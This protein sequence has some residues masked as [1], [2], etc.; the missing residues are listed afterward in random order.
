[1]LLAGGEGP[2]EASGTGPVTAIKPFELLLGSTWTELTPPLSIPSRA[3]VAAAVDLRTGAA[4]L[5]GGQA[6]PDRPGVTVYD[7]LTWFDPAAA[8]V[9]EASQPLRKGQLTDAVAVA[10]GNVA[11]SSTLGGIVLVGGRDGAGNVL[12]QISGVIWGPSPAGGLDFVDDTTFSGAQWKLPSPRAH[13]VA[14]R[15]ADD[16]VLTAGGVTSLALGAFD[17]SNATAAITLIDPAGGQVRDLP[18]PLSQARADS[19]A[20]LLEDGTALIAGGAWKD[21]GGLHSAKS[22]DLVGTDHSVRTPAGPDSL[23]GSG[24]LGAARHRAACIR[25]K[26]GTVLVSGGLQ[27]PA[28]G[29]T[30]VVLDS[31]EIYQPL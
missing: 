8:A 24:I 1:M 12:D 11:G 22:V 26:D 10:R 27:Y 6:G 18:D 2:T 25:L 9:N 3:H 23:P 15:T 21:A 28:A 31:A 29:G 19:C 4:V 16:M 20:L 17:Y 5:A 14:L 7:T 30:P 13:H